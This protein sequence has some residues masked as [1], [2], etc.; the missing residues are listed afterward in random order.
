MASYSFPFGEKYLRERIK[1]VTLTLLFLT[2]FWG[3]AWTV[4]PT[5]TQ[6]IEI[7]LVNGTSRC[8]G[9]LEV[10]HNG[11]WGTVCDD[12]WGIEDARV[13]CRQLGCASAILALRESH[14]GRGTGRIWM[15]E[16]RCVGTESFL[17]QCPSRPWGDNDCHHGEDAGVVCSEMRLAGGSTLCTGRVEVLFNQRWGT[18]CDNG[19]DLADANVVC[20]EVGC[21]SALA[22][23]GA[24][25]FGQGTGPIWMDQV[26]CTGE[27]DSLRKCPPKIMREHSCSHSKD[28][29][30][31]CAEPPEI[32]L[33]NGPNH[34]SGRVE[35]LHE[36]LWGTICDDDWD[37]DDAKVVCQYLGCGNALSAP[38]GSRFGPGAG[39]IWLDGVNCT[40][41][42]TAISKCPAKAWGEHDCTH[43]EDSGV[44]CTE[45]RLSQGSTRCSGRLEVYHN[46]QWGTVCD[47]D[48]DLNDAN[49]VCRELECGT[50]LKA[51]G[52]AQFGQG[53]GTIWLDRVNCTGKE[54]FLNECPKRPWGEH[55]CDHS[56]DTSVECSDP[57]EVRLVNGTSRCSGRVEVLHN[58][59]WGTVCDD[60]WELTNA[61]VVCRELG[62]GIALS[63]P[64]GA[65]YGKGNDPIWL[66]DVKCKGTE[67]SLRDCRLK[68]WGEHNCN[69]GEDAGAMCSELRLVNGSSHCSGRVEIFHDQQWGTVCDDRWDIKHAEVICREMGC[70]VALKARRKAYFG[71][72][73]GPIWLDDVNC[74]G[75]ENSL[76][77][78]QASTW[79][80]NNCHH[81]EDAGVE[82]ADPV[83]LRLVN[84]S[85]RCTG[86]VEVFHLQQ[87]GTVCDDNWDLNEAVVVCRYLD[88]GSAISAPRSARFGRGTDAIWLDD[89][90]CTGTELSLGVCKAKPWGTNDCNHG[91]DAGVVCS[92]NLRL[93]NGTNRCSGRVEIRTPGSDEWGTVCDR[94]W[95]LKD[96]EIVCRQLGCGSAG[97]AP[98]GA[99]FGRGSGRIWMDD[100]NCE[101]TENSLQE[102]RANTRGT[103]NCVHD[104]DA[105]VICSDTFTLNVAKIRLEDGPNSCAGR[106]EVYHQQQWGTVCDDG[107]GLQ[108]VAVV[109]RQLKC[110]IPLESLSGA[111][112]GRGSGPIFLDDVNCTGTEMSIKE[113]RGRSVGE[114]DCDHAEDAGAICSGP[115]KVRLANGPNACAGRVELNYNGSWVSIGDSDWS[116]NE[117]RVI[118]QQLGCGAALSVSKGNEYGKSTGPAFLDNMK[119]KGTESSLAECQAA[120]TSSKKCIC[121]SYAGAV[122]E[123]QSGSGTT[124]AVIL[125]LVIIVLLIGVLLFYLWKKGVKLSA[126][127]PFTQ[128]RE[129]FME[130]ISVGSNMVNGLREMYSRG[131]EQITSEGDAEGDTIC[132]VKAPSDPSANSTD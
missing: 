117:A 12:S 28:A 110:G 9:R 37:L 44:V 80:T 29:G 48:W 76:S 35:I 96:V 10:F 105:S 68:S 52:G 51:T 114:H 81:Q 60:G 119:C 61:Q 98:K 15:D 26:N 57:N 20:R 27:E 131:R 13:V 102:C 103:N 132:L 32:R 79:G 75:T 46:K 33:S 45:L 73:K 43:S 101:G 17:N 95:D 115:L 66:D 70:G 120:A 86:R 59:Q 93:V 123:G 39:P 6:P 7:R 92:E 72:G 99:H 62:C 87:Y 67:A 58:Q 1:E 100:V 38:R 118:C 19:W 74:Q 107:W 8:V 49:V 126:L 23:A 40:G 91:E 16:V 89:V 65:K 113:C 47:E 116:L 130:N 83:E 25:K 4:Q 128:R 106:V 112:F 14:F 21:G 54:A 34:C 2:C 5:A 71:Q 125:S 109:C 55:S 88:C 64:R 78:C 24:A 97:S 85:H 36:K 50:A 30:V 90:E 41:S 3:I 121:G 42:E 124:T 127:N 56:R 108:D 18:I 31:E 94:T 22:T 77:E 11:L 104:Q 53:S 122:C 84:G 129:P 111:H 82:C 63:A 69:H